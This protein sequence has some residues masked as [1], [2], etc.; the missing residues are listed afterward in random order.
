MPVALGVLGTSY[1]G[2][3]RT[4]YLDV[5]GKCSQGQFTEPIEVGSPGQFQHT[6]TEWEV[7]P[8]GVRCFRQSAFAGD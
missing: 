1:F 2:N 7:Q 4:N 5:L 3:L 8:V 6:P